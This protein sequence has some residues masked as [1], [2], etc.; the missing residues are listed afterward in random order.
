[1]LEEVKN[2]LKI[3]VDGLVATYAYVETGKGP[4]L[5]SNYLGNGPESGTSYESRSVKRTR[6]VSSL[7]RK[8]VARRHPGLTEK[9]LLATS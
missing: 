1:M 2:S 3:C 4:R 6:I 9:E 8:S 7:P 5:A